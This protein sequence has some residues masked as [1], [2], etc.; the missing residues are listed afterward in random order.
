M[1]L[2]PFTGVEISLK[3]DVVEKIEALGGTNYNDLMT[4]VNYLIVGDRETEKYQFCIKNR[5]DIVFLAPEAIL[6][7]HKHWINGEDE[8]SDLLK[9]ENYKLP[10][11]AGMSVCL[12][13][14]G[15]S[16]SQIDHLVNTVEFRPKNAKYDYFTPRN[17]LKVFYK[18]GGEAKET[19]QRSQDFII[20]ADP[21]GTRYNKAIEWNVPVVHPIW[22]VD[23]V[24]RGGALNIEDYILTGNPSDCFDRGCNV[25]MEVIKFNENHEKTPT[26]KVK[27]VE[28]EVKRKIITNKNNADIWNSI[29]DRTKM[30]SKKLTRDKTWDDEDEDD[31]E[32]ENETKTDNDDDD[33]SKPILAESKTSSTLSE[34]S[35]FL[36]FNFCTLGF[37]DRQTDL[38]T[39]TIES[40]Q[41]EF[42][43][44]VNDDSITHVVIP[45]QKGHKSMEVLKALPSELKSRIT[46]GFVHVVTE[47]YLERCMFY[48]KI[49]LDR[50]G[51]PMKGLIPSKKS[52]RICISGFVGVELLHIQKLIE[53]LQFEF[54]ETLSDQRDLLILNINLFKPSFMKNSPKLFQYKCKDII[55]CPTG[56]SLSLMASKN[57]IEA[58]KSWGIPVVSVAYLWEILELSANKSHVV[59]PDITDLQWCIFAPINY[60]KPR[61]LLEYVKNM[62][63]ASREN[64]FGPEDD[65]K[66]ESNDDD[67]Q[68]D[69]ESLT[70]VKLPSPRR[71]NS[72]QKYGKLIPESSTSPKSIKNRLLEAANSVTTPTGDANHDTNPDIT[73]DEDLSMISQIRYHDQDS[74]L[75]QEKLLEKL[76]GSTMPPIEE[77][78][79]KRRRVGS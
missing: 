73:I 15:L 38:L 71:I 51:Q 49:I 45:A 52:F 78:S 41:G 18:N 62:D 54:C 16:T 17:L 25:W 77:S 35:L 28:P 29:M 33:D 34:S 22:I 31:D 5:S 69:A 21:R 23:S 30:Q 13:R 57:K 3:R 12:S 6:T 14:I 63:K 36:G 55:N 50:W 11:F 60:S 65:H 74:M 19:L 10:I 59:M 20:T 53:A 26:E 40:F 48:K 47:F 7:V 1:S 56:G 27:S 75:N 67:F 76:E 39:K 79:S 37:D 44:D 43:S 70:S 8:S 46:N 61:S 66:Q 2:K 58:A 64:S 9:L 32:E 42:T 72:R 68:G 4:D 24:L